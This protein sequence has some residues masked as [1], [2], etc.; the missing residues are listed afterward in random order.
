MFG[1]EKVHHNRA[2]CNPLS[3]FLQLCVRVTSRL[4]V[5]GRGFSRATQPLLPVLLCSSLPLGNPGNNPGAGWKP[6]QPAHLDD[7][8]RRKPSLRSRFGHQTRGGRSDQ[9]CQPSRQPIRILRTDK[10][11]VPAAPWMVGLV[12][13]NPDAKP[14]NLPEARSRPQVVDSLLVLGSVGREMQESARD[15]PPLPNLEKAEP[16]PTCDAAR[17]LPCVCR[18]RIL[19]SRDGMRLEKSKT[20]DGLERN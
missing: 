9:P 12:W 14:R 11:W 7:S 1:W 3:H 19:L 6:W 8:P 2:H 10:L 15:P 16:M 18:G 13:H 5:R 20:W 17:C 4:L